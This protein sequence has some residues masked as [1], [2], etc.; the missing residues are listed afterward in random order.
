MLVDIAFFMFGVAAAG[1]LGLIIWNWFCG[2]P[3]RTYTADDLKDYYGEEN[4]KDFSFHY[5][6]P[7]P[8]EQKATTARRVKRNAS[9]KK[10]VRKPSN[11][12]TRKGTRRGR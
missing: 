1:L 8:V 5:Y 12:G 6:T 7:T 10:P 11:K 9:R 2:A 3:E 4:A